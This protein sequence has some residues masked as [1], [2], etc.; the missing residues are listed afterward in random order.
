MNFLSKNKAYLLIISMILL[1]VLSACGTST[2]KEKD[3]E[4]EP[5]SETKS[6]DT[7][8]A[9]EQQTEVVEAEPIVTITMEN[10]DAITIELYPNIAPN[11]VNNFISLI[12]EGYY[13]GLIFHRVIPGFMIQGGDPDGNGMGGPGYTI[14]GEFSSNDFDNDLEHERG[15]LS[16]ARTQ[17]PNSAGSQFFIMT[18]VS[19]QLD[20]DYAAFGQVIEGMEAVDSI[21]DAKTG[22]QDKP[23]EDQKIKTITV[24]TDGYDFPDPITE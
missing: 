6:E 14:E 8:S 4:A 24:D 15:I 9:A 10:E 13:D 22:S 21:V 23:V 5:E 2:E 1:V 17:D 20:G 7:K 3:N 18:E 16:M 12:E 19:E 11:T